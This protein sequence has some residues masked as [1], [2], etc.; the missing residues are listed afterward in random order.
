[1]TPGQSAPGQSNPTPGINWPDFHSGDGGAE[2][3]EA[4]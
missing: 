2:L 4:A 1:M 3:P